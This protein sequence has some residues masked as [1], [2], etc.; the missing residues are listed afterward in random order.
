MK[1]LFEET[2]DVVVYVSSCQLTVMTSTELI[3]WG[4]H[5]IAYTSRA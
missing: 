3:A 1:L 2:L 5:D 4:A